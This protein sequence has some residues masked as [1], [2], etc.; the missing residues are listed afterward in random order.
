MRTGH[1][2]TVFRRCYQAFRRWKA[3]GQVESD[4]KSEEGWSP[5]AFQGKPTKSH[6]IHAQ[7]KE[8]LGSWNE[9]VALKAG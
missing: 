8:N 9:Q 1:Q 4:L 7:S 5:D 6:L 2:A 3:D